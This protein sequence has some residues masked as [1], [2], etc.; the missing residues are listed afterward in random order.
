MGGWGLVGL[1]CPLGLARR[2]RQ[3]DRADGEVA[4][5]RRKGDG[6][7]E[8]GVARRVSQLDHASKGMLNKWLAPC[9]SAEPN[10]MANM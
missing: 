2:L 7:G 9:A 10:L 8:A 6:L 1:C 5:G 4:S 3:S